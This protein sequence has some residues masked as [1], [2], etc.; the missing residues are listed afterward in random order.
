MS[1]NTELGVVQARL[2]GIVLA[3]GELLTTANGFSRR[4]QSSSMKAPTY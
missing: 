1:I 2:G 3:G 4:E